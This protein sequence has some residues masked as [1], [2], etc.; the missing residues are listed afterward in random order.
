MKSRLFAFAL[1]SAGL[2]G[3]L[4]KPNPED[5]VDGWSMARA[6]LVK[7]DQCFALRADYCISDPEFVDAAIRPRLVDLY[8]GEMPARKVHVEAIVR[9]AINEYRRALMKPE[10]VARVE[11]LVKERYSN[12]KVALEPDEV[13]VDMGVVPG[14]IEPAPATLGLRMTASDYVDNGAWTEV[15]ARKALIAYASKYPTAPRIRVAVTIARAT[16]LGKR[17]LS[18]LAQREA[19]RRV[20]RRRDSFDSSGKRR[21][22][23]HHRSQARG[24][25]ALQAARADGGWSRRRLSHRSFRRPPRRLNA[26]ARSPRPIRDLSRSPR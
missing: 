23:R 14:H 15:E 10:N 19:T 7:G 12:P 22:A 13:N 9:A 8:G 2:A 24:H 16:G 17:G 21:R 3:C 11:E 4:R 26:P 1:V 20:H 5:T 18:V 25:E 6:A